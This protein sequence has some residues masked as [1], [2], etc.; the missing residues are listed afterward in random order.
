MK[1]KDMEEII[2]PQRDID[3]IQHKKYLKEIEYENIIKY[4]HTQRISIDYK[5][6]ENN[7]L[8]SFYHPDYRFFSFD[9]LLRNVNL[10]EKDILHYIIHNK[11][12]LLQ[13]IYYMTLY[14]YYLELIDINNT[15]I[16]NDNLHYASYIDYKNQLSLIEMQIQQDIND[17]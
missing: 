1:D 4:F 7:F 8:I 5:P 12:R 16:Q 15:N 14:N 3:L 2:Y 10:D 11:D 9:Y 6:L 17:N 13:Y